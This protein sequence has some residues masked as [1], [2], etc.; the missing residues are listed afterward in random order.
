MVIDI[1]PNFSEL[2]KLNISLQEFNQTIVSY[3]SG[4][5]IGQWL[6]GPRNYSI[7]L[8]LSEN[9]RQNMDEIKNLPVPLP[10][11]ESVALFKIANIQIL[12]Q[13][14]TVARSWGQRYAALSLNISNRDTGSFVKDIEQII[15][16]NPVNKD[17][18]IILG[19]Q[20]NNLNRAKKRLFLII[21]ITLL[22]ILFILWREF[23]SFK[24]AILIFL[25]VPLAT[26][27]GVIA[28]YV[29]EI[30]LSLSAA[31]GFIALIGIALLNGIVLLTVFNQ[32]KISNNTASLKELIIEGTLS[33]LRPVVMT[34]LV[35]SIGF[36]PMAVNSGLGSEVQ[37]PLATVVIGGILFST[38]LTLIV[39]P[40]LYLA[41]H[42]L[43]NTEK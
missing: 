5:K 2:A 43:N 34:A 37:K 40:C 14:T 19:G 11:G 20:F 26:F 41:L 30:H 36:I 9:L 7:V 42:S 8:H 27:G 6:Q 15:Q 12:P 1:K 3:M 13:V 10:E 17:H 18:K 16:D 22:L 38:L 23:S 31:V 32:L 33:R 39:F 21:P 25:C 29:R 28:L 35:A 4:V 24:D